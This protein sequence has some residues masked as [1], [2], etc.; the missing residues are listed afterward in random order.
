M[1]FGLSDVDFQ[2]L[3][4]LVINPLK[5]RGAKVFIFGSRVRGTHHPFSDVDILFVPKSEEEP[6]LSELSL[7]KEAVEE[8]RLGVKID[9]VSERELAKSYKSHVFAERVEV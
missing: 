5:H 9:I 2:L 3:E 7:I 6:S 8:S 4:N 1:K